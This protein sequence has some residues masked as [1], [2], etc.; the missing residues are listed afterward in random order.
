ME[1]V[2]AAG[3]EEL[4]HEISS[5]LKLLRALVRETAEG[6]ILRKEG[7]IETLLAYQRSL[8]PAKL[9]AVATPWLRELRNLKLKPAKGKL[10][11]LKK[12]DALLVELLNQVIEADAAASGEKSSSGKI[13]GKLTADSKS[14]KGPLHDS[15]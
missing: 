8:S 15:A 3:H 11:D 4:H 10:N 2:K 14:R 9:R 7:E 6:F 5:E 12:I 13:E 1:L